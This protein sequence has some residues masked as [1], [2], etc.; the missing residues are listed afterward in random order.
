MQQIF[1]PVALCEV[2]ILKIRIFC[3]LDNGDI[4]VGEIIQNMLDAL[5]PQIWDLVRNNKKSRQKCRKLL[6][7]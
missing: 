5:A 6:I 2:N 7:M 3:L 4:D 1:D